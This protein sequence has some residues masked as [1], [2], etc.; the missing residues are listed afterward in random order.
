MRI[1]LI[2][3]F[4]TVLFL[5]FFCRAD[6]LD[7][8]AERLERTEKIRVVSADF[9]QVRHLNDLDMDVR[10]TGSML[11][12]VSGHLRWQVDS[13]LR[14][15]TVIRKEMLEHFDAST[16]KKIRVSARDFPWMTL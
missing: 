7:D 12:D 4:S 16:G 1:S 3:L 8:L 15:V 14:S 6:A 10:I 9:I 11:C 2:L 13:P 5:P